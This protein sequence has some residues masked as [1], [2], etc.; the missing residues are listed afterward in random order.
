MKNVKALKIISVFLIIAMVFVGCSQ[1]EE[2][3]AQEPA[4]ETPVAETPVAEEPAA[5]PEPEKIDL[6]G[7]TI[8]IAAW[9]DADP[10]K[11]EEAKRSAYKIKQIEL[12]EEVEK[13]YNCKIEYVNVGWGEFVQ[14]F[15]TTSLAGEPFA[16]IVRL[17]L[18]WMFP[19]MVEDGFVAELDPWFNID[20]PKYIPWMKKGGKYKGK[21]YG[22]IDGNPSG[23]GIWYNKSMFERLGIEDPY[24]LQKNG[25]WTW[26]KLLEI[27]KAAT[28]DTDGDGKTDV[29]GLTGSSG[30]LFHM[31]VYSN[32]GSVDV[33]SDGTFQYSLTTENA[34][35]GAQAFYD[36]YNTHNVIELNPEDTSKSFVEG[37]AAM[38]THFTW[39]VG[40]FKDNMT[41]QLGFVF[42]PKGPKADKY[43]TFTPW[44]NM[45][46]VSKTSKNAEAAARI[47]DDMLL[48]KAEYPELQ[49]LVDDSLEATYPS[50]EIIDTVKQMGANVE[51]IGYYAYPNGEK[52]V[53]E[54]VNNMKDGKET[55]ATALEKIK[56]QFE[57]AMN[58][59][60]K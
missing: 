44:G 42:F 41:D 12:I 3:A 20:D 21:Q 33:A 49:V 18:F 58:E 23:F 17:E 36:F 10:R 37:K 24:E 47:L 6:Q 7:Q 28:Q 54:A 53:M 27:S 51:Y 30:E 32:K 5:E 9:W 19:K 55:P 14:T 22:M 34:M 15:T 40:H 16:D 31:F 50:K 38:I 2:P 57:A 43:T 1:P 25:Q 45:W 4:A 35:Q 39:Q 11:V 48:W 56:P 59:I 29:Y 8:K 60:L 13:K 26:E 46:A 52:I